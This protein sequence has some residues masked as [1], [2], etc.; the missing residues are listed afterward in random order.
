MKQFLVIYVFLLVLV[1]STFGFRGCKSSRPP[2]EIFQDM[3]RQAK[4]HPQ[5]VNPFFADNR[6]DRPPV[7][8]TVPFAASSQSDYRYLTPDAPFVEDRYFTTGLTEGGVPGDVLPIE[9][10]AQAMAEGQAHYNTFCAICHGTS[11]NGAGV[12]ADPRYN[13]T[14]IASLL[15]QRIIDQPE[16]EIFQTITNGRNTM[17]PYGSKLRPEERWKV[18]LYVRALQRAATATVDDVPPEHRRDLGL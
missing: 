14:T 4:I 10:T 1:L 7:P 13:Y 6:G 2:L 5:G 11:G 15:Q 17:G 3:D 12:V 9:I 16:G 18:V 8:G